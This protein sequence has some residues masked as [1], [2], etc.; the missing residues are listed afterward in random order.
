MILVNIHT[1]LLLS[2]T[3]I[4]NLYIT[5]LSHIYF[6]NIIAYYSLFIVVIS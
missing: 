1:M 3:P 2:Q 5:L 4:S 6:Y